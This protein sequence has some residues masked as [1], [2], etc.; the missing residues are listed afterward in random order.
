MSRRIN[1]DEKEKFQEDISAVFATCWNLAVKKHP[2]EV[3]KDFEQFLTDTTL[4]RMKYNPQIPGFTLYFDNYSHT[5]H[6]QPF[7]PPS[8]QSAMN[9]CRYIHR[10]VN[11]TRYMIL[12]Y[13]N[14]ETHYGSLSPLHSGANFFLAD[15]GVRVQNASDTSICWEPEKAHS[16][17]L[18][19]KGDSFQQI[20][21]SIGIGNRLKNIWEKHKLEEFRQVD[22]LKE[23]E[24]EITN[25]NIEDI[26][27]E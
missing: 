11:A 19:E 26:E 4:P 14:R 22:M 12:W 27:I 18:M 1:A 25:I 5:F 24:E 15:Y 21:L 16:T 6:N 13:T 17:S 8:G 3:I 20:G 23:L 2:I 9:Y 10:E 7:A